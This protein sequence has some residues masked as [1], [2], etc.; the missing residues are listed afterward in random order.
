M[1]K[2]KRLSA[3]H[4]AIIIFGTAF[5]ASLAR[6]TGSIH[7]RLRHNIQT[8][9]RRRLRR[10][11]AD[12]SGGQSGSAALLKAKHL[13]FNAGHDL[14]VLVVILEKVGNVKKGVALEAD[15]NEC[16]LHSGQNP[17]DPSFVNTAGERIFLLSL[18]IN[19]NYLIVL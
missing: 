2:I 11:V 14:V 9:N 18:V 17:R 4:I 16:R 1:K 19:L 13:L 7:R 3:I 5:D 10:R 12:G 15:V 8:R 6:L